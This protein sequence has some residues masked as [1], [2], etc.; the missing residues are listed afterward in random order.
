[1]HFCRVVSQRESSMFYKT[2]SFPHASRQAW[3][4]SRSHINACQWEARSSSSALQLVMDDLKHDEYW[5]AAADQAEQSRRARAMQRVDCIILYDD[6]ND[7]PKVHFC[8]G[9]A[10]CPRAYV[11]L[12]M[13]A[14]ERGHGNVAASSNYDFS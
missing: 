4:W 10:A 14:G 11:A 6:Y 8:R 12:D 2:C 9:V 5:A 3:T 1:M 13:P 7:A